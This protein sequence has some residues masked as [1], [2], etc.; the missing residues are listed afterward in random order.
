MTYQIMCE[1]M[2]GVT[3]YRRGYLTDSGCPCLFS[4]LDRA[5]IE[6]NRLTA[7]NNQP[8]TRA[9]FRYTAEAMT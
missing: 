5:Q 8:N 9:T 6:A 4:S 3:G 2:G 7:I 1:V